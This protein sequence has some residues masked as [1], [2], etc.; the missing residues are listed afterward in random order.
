MAKLPSVKER[1]HKG[2]AQTMDATK[3]LADEKSLAIVRAIVGLGSSFGITTTAEG[4]E[5]EDQVN[6]LDNEGC[7]EVQGFLYSEPLPSSEI[8]PFLGRHRSVE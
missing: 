4:V 3:M 8:Q 6:C 7:T 1:L 2:Y 5:N